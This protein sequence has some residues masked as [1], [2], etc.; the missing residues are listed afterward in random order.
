MREWGDIVK[1][2]LLLLNLI[3]ILVANAGVATVMIVVIK[4]LGDAGLGIRQIGKDGPVA[5][6][7]RLSF[8][9]GPAAF[10]LGRTR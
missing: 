9:A 7:E 8:E 10:G 5:G 2:L 3:K 4:I 1:L 6:F